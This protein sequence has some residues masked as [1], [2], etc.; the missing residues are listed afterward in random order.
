M[1]VQNAPSNVSCASQQYNKGSLAIQFT[2]T[3]S[4]IIIQ[5]T[6]NFYTA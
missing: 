3:A 1:F 2:N 4:T 6:E 5:K